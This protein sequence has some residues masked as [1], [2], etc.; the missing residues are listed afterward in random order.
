[1]NTAPPNQDAT[2]LILDAKAA[3]GEGAL[4]DANAQR[5]WWVDILSGHLH[6][7]D[8]NQQANHVFDVGQ[9]VGTVVVRRRGG[10]MLAVEN[11]FAAYDPD[12]G[13]LDLIA[14]PEANKL[15]NRFN[16][17]KCDP[18]GRFWAG[19]IRRD[20]ANDPD[21]A[22]YRLDRDLTVHKMVDGVTNS[23]GIVWT[24]DHQTMYYIDTPTRQVSA[25][26]FDPQRGAI[27][28]RRP[29]VEIPEDLGWPDGMAIDAEDKLWIAQWGGACVAR[30]DPASGALLGKVEVPAKQVTSCAFGGPDL[31]ELYITTARKGLDEPALAQQPLAGGLFKARPG[32][33]GVESFEFAG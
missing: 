33:V 27:A 17:G 29:A 11:G 14:D 1:M 28:N 2:E 24:A 3:L 32:V 18:A 6:A 4:W 30:F 20:D 25:F 13:H 10:L 8:P 31:D 15:H 21:A 12:R 5:L 26:D 16:D 19:T 22:L 9:M 7:H 23:N